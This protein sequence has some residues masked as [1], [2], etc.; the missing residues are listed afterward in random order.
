M[1]YRIRLTVDYD[2]VPDG[3]GFTQLGQQQ[4]N[5]PGTG[6]TQGPG[7]VGAAQTL[8]LIQAET[9]P[10]GD[11]PTQSNFNTALLNAIADIETQMGTVGAAFG[12]GNQT[13]LALIQGFSSGNP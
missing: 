3:V 6:S 8:S 2:W 10:G 1:A 4:S 11:S 9:V 12:V 5:N 13:P 7:T